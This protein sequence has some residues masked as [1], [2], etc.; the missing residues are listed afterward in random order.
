[1]GGYPHATCGHA[2]ELVIFPA[3]ANSSNCNSFLST[4]F[5]SSGLDSASGGDRPI[6]VRQ[7]LAGVDENPNCRDYLLLTG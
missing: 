7:E 2:S 3:S 6:G 5:D 1:M 4:S